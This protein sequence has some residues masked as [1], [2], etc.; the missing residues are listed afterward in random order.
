M[1]KGLL[2]GITGYTLHLHLY[3]SGMIS[4]TEHKKSNVITKYALFAIALEI[5]RGLGVHTF[6]KQ[7]LVT[8]IKAWNV[9]TYKV[10]TN[11]HFGVWSFLTLLIL[12]FAIILQENKWVEIRSRM[13]RTQVVPCKCLFQD[14]WRRDR[15]VDRIA[16][17]RSKIGS[18]GRTRPRASRLS[19]RWGQRRTAEAGEDHRDYGKSQATEGW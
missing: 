4:V 19:T 6:L 11:S 9:G 8:T 18:G 14:W 5:P 2:T 17:K 15:A 10:G 1:I 3:D 7:I 13:S 16:P 12:L